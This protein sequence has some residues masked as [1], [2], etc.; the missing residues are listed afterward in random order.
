MERDLRPT[1]QELLRDNV[2][3]TSG[4]VVRRAT[5]DAIG[6]FDE[7]PDLR[8]VEDFDLWLRLLRHRD[9]SILVLRE[10]LFSYRL[11]ENSI[12]R[13]D[14]RRDLELRKRVFSKHLDFAGGAIR[15]LVLRDETSVR[16]GELQVALR[17]GKLAL[18]AW[19]RAPE[20]PLRRRLRLAAK[21]IL[22]GRARV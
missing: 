22:L 13:A 20:V 14:P 4:T 3:S 6:L 8:A 10:P 9:R 5:F 16:R 7:D 2:V 21:A 19:L 18:G 15:A 1:F 17:D 12:S 11:S